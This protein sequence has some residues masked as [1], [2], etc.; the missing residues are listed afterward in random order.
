[1]KAT[2]GEDAVKIVDMTTKDSEYYIN[3]VDKAGAGFDSNFERTF[4]MG[5]MLSNS[6]ACYREIVRERKSQL[7]WRTSSLSYFKKKHSHPG[8]QQPPP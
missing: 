5:K 7:M 6:M 4:T 3:L 1:M 2:P 8:P